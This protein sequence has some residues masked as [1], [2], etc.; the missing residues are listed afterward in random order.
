MLPIYVSL[1]G[2][3][4]VGIGKP[5]MALI[6]LISIGGGYL[7]VMRRPECNCA[8]PE[9]CPFPEK[10]SP[11]NARQNSSTVQTDLDQKETV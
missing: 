11:A 8:D 10:S 9:I 3:K 6:S 1:F 5:V 4:A 2:S 7:Y